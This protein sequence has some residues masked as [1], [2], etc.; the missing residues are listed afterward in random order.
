MPSFFRPYCSRALQRTA[1]KQTQMRRDIVALRV[2]SHHLRYP[3]RAAQYSSITRMYVCLRPKVLITEV[4]C[5]NARGMATITKARSLLKVFKIRYIV[6][7][8]AVAG[9]ISL[10]TVSSLYLL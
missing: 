10:K 5:G 3:Y 8:S 9:G 6:I 1:S 4:S 7:G 2:P